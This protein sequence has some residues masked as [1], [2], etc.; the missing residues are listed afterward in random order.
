MKSDKHIVVMSVSSSLMYRVSMVG[1]Q[2]W[3]ITRSTIRGMLD[4]CFKSMRF[5]WAQ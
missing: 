1:F 4:I 5:P 2:R 3:M